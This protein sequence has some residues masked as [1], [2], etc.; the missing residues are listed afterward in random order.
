MVSLAGD[1]PGSSLRQPASLLLARRLLVVA[2]LERGDLA[3]AG[4]QAAAYERLARRAGIPRYSWLPEIWRGMRALLDGNPDLALRYAAAAEQIGRRARSL[5]AELMV[6]TVRM[7]AHLDPGTPEQYAGDIT[8]M[9]DRPGMANFPAMYLAAPG[10]A[11]LAAGDAGHARTALQ[12]F[13]T[14]PAQA[15]P[16][17]AEWLESHWALADI[18]LHLD[19]GLAAAKLFDA[20]RP[21]ESLWAVDGLGAVVFGTIAEP[22][23]RWQPTS[24]GRARPAGT[25]PRHG[26]GT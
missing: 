3:G 17:D 19:A 21:H 25:W 13:L 7:Q 20:L 12:M 16:R 24:A 11:L 9:L 10:R 23:G 18:A 5:N 14:G 8:G 2:H 1:D 4:E 15:M 6:F 22:L 26:N